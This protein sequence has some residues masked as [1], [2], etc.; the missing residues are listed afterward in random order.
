M[1]V[2]HKADLDFVNAKAHACRS[3]LYEKDR[4]AA[5]CGCR[6][7]FELVRQLYPGES[8]FDH[9]ADPAT[10]LQRRLVADHV[11]ALTRLSRALTGRHQDF[12]GWMLRRYSIENFK[13]YLRALAENAG[14]P[15]SGLVPLPL[16]LALPEEACRAAKDV[17]ALLQALPDPVL[18]AG[19]EAALDHYRDKQKVFFIETALDQAYFNEL[20]QRGG[21]LP[22]ADGQTSLPL[23]RHEIDAYSVLGV[24]RLRLYH[25]AEFSDLKGFLPTGGSLRPGD[26]RRISDGADF[27]AMVAAVPSTLRRDGEAIAEVGDLEAALWT[28]LYHR[29]NRA[30]YG[31]MVDL[32]PAVAFAYLKRAELANLIRISEALRLGMPRR[33]ILRRLIPTWKE[34]PS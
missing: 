6:D 28:G 31:P 1:T 13:V 30:F 23:V 12:Y 22:R 7:L 18:R 8:V 16:V 26:L 29:A 3:M 34:K 24:I 10:E 2:F 21:R 20:E 32:G 25:Q 4:L 33:D 14:L 9:W 5:L 15:P 27:Q 11:E 17:P 19:A